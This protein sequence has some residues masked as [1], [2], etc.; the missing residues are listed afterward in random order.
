MHCQIEKCVAQTCYR[1]MLV[2]L[3]PFSVDKSGDNP[4]L[5]GNFSHRN[6]HFQSPKS[7]FSVTETLCF[8]H[9]QSPKPTFSVTEK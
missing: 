9:F 2:K 3:S 6:R 8:R 4:A 5:L 7:T 1:M